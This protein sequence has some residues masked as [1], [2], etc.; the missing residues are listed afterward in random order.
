MRTKEEYYQSVQKYRKIINDPENQTCPCQKVKCEWHGKCKECVTLHR[1]NKDHIP[2]CFQPFIK[3][4]IVQLAR[5]VEL[6]PSEKEKTPPEYWDHVRE[7]DQLQ[8]TEE[9]AKC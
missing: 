1:A 2:N 7:Q 4:S 5:V 9:D 6:I 3:E 8:K